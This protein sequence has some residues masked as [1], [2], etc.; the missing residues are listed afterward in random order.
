M[1]STENTTGAYTLPQFR[2]SLEAVDRLRLRLSHRC[3][4]QLGIARDYVPMNWTFKT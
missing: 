1:K 2:K 3:L 4:Q